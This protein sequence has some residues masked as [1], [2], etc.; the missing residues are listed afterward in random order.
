MDARMPHHPRAA[1][2]RGMRHMHTCPAHHPRAGSPNDPCLSSRPNILK[3]VASQTPK[4]SSL[5]G[6]HMMTKSDNGLKS[7]PSHV[8]HD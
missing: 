7:A 1:Q 8:L 6:W 4:G 5:F 2:L 3:C